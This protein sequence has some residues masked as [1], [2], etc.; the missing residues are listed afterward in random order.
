MASPRLAQRAEEGADVFCQ[1]FWLLQG[2]KVAA[3]RHLR[4]MLYVI[5]AFGPFPGDAADEVLAR[6]HRHARWHFNSLCWLRSR[7]VLPPLVIA[8]NG[9]TDRLYHPV[10][11]NIGEQ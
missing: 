2:G 10:D 6:K 5:V 4:P 1:Q 3:A 7:C 11:S 8:A 9:R